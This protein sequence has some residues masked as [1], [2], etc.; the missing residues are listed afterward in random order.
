M[1]APVRIIDFPGHLRMRPKL[2]DILE[3]CC[4]VI[5]VIDSTTFIHEGMYVCAYVYMYAYTPISW[6]FDILE[7]CCGVIFVID[8]TTFIHEGM[9]VC[10]YVR[11]YA[12]MYVCLHTRPY[13]G[14]LI[15]WR[16]A[17]A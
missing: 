2:F 11:K 1:E 15:C 14:C 5:F 16:T 9:Y 12:R 4:G 13:V 17:V 8:S 3:D 6:M 10:L 7:D